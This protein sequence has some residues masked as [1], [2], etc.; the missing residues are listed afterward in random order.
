[1]RSNNFSLENCFSSRMSCKLKNFMLVKKLTWVN[2]RPWCFS[3][4]TAWEATPPSV[5]IET[6]GR[7]DCREP[8]AAPLVSSWQL[9]RFVA[10][11][12][13]WYLEQYST[14]N[15]YTSV[16]LTPSHDVP[17]RAWTLVRLLRC[18]KLEIMTT[19]CY[20]VSNF[21]QK[22]GLLFWAFNFNITL[23]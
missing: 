21:P 9:S 6:W 16:R 17:L 4:S 19:L 18:V 20:R 5:T 15:L 23:F 22:N 12:L 11:G 14:G 1:M 7:M 2:Y 3:L 13:E 8:H 10:V